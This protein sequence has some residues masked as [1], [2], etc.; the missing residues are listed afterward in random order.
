MPQV[1]YVQPDG[2]RATYRLVPGESVLDGALDNGVRGILGQ[3]GGGC[4][5]ATCHCYVPEP[6][7]SRLAPPDQDELDILEYVWEPR[8]NS[9]LACQIRVGPALDDLVVVVPAQQ[10]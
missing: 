6:F 3:C 2:S 4:T 9:R 1:T 7:F 10:A 8:A 5:C